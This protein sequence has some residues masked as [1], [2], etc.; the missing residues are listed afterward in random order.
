M[1]PVPLADS[2]DDPGH[3]CEGECGQTGSNL[4][5][6]ISQELP[7]LLPERQ[8]A[9]HARVRTIDHLAGELRHIVTQHVGLHVGVD[10]P[11]RA[12]LVK[13]ALGALP[14]HLIG[15]LQT[16]DGLGMDHV[17]ERRRQDGKLMEVQAVAAEALVQEVL[18]MPRDSL[19]QGSDRR[20]RRP[21]FALWSHPLDLPP[22]AL[23]EEPVDSVTG[24][25][26][27]DGATLVLRQGSEGVSQCLSDILETGLSGLPLPRAERLL[28]AIQE[29]DLVERIR[30]GLWRLLKECVGRNNGNAEEGEQGQAHATAARHQAKMYEKGL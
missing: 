24:P 28:E 11:F 14:V 2:L 25:S 19:A 16:L 3:I 4:S 20:R 12:G 21:S 17:L 30:H 22:V 9:V 15:S 29:S 27:A 1:L 26:C 8:N 10:D 18:D 13:H 6:H 23:H 5:L 7:R